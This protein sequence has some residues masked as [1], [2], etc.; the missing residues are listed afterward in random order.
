MKV[1]EYLERLNATDDVTFI[2]AM[3]QKD[4][5]SFY[6]EVFRTTPIRRVYEWVGA[7]EEFLDS[8]VLNDKQMPIDW[9][10]GANWTG[11]VKRGRL[12]CLLII[13]Q[14]DYAA[15]LP[16]KDQRESIERFIEKKLG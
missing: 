2:V 10:S 15:L 1:R 14:D 8:V 9:L 11:L 6:D 5:G 4:V 7:S 16:S 13:P 12:K 3:A